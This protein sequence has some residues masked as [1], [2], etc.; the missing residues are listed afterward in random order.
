MALNDNDLLLIKYAGISA[1]D[2]EKKN[3]E[4]QGKVLADGFKEYMKARKMQKKPEYFENAQKIVPKIKELLEK[5]PTV[6]YKKLLKEGKTSILECQIIGYS[7]SEK[8]Y[9]TIN[10]NS[11]SETPNIL[12]LSEDEIITKSD[13]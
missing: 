5:P 11:K 10:L 9:L 4:E 7:A 3:E 2:F 8:K 12:K 13:K 1:E 6:Y